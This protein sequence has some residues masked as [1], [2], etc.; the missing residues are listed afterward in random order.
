LIRLLKKPAPPN[1]I[2][3][4]I[5]AILIVFPILQ[6]GAFLVRPGSSA[7]QG[8]TVAAEG[9][10]VQ[11]GQA[12]PDVYYIILDEYGREDVLKEV[13]N[14]DNSEF[15]RYLKNKGFY[16]ADQGATN[17]GITL[18]SISSSLNSTYLDGYVSPKPGDEK[19][20]TQQII[21]MVNRSKARSAFEQ[22]GYRFVSF[23]TGYLFTEIRDADLYYQPDNYIN[24]FEMEYINTTVLSLG[25][26][27]IYGPRTRG[28]TLNTIH[29]LAE[30]P[31]IAPDRPKFVFAHILAAHVPFVF[32]PNGEAVEPWTF[33]MAASSP[34]RTYK[35]AYK[36]QVT[37]INKL[38]EAT[39]D[40]I[41]AKS[42][43]KPVIILQGDHGPETLLDW[44]SIDNTCLKERMTILNAYYLPGIDPQK[45]YPTI[46]PV[47]TFR[48]VEDH[49]LGMHE[50]LLEDHSY[51]STWDK[52]YQY[53]DVT[54]RLNSC[55][56]K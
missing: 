33:S 14:Y 38:M 10:S 2:L 18:M 52:S 5:S 50:G 28:L 40:E 56:L 27:A 19:I 45:L 47:N 17:Y 30:L 16:V 37:Y 26:G 4:I 46:T 7:Q 12:L 55:K 32:G 21:H 3:N 6:I 8:K 41:L 49:Y 31:T 29:R 9:V 44:Y 39:I 24:D 36:D 51:F 15:I 22:A 11:A 54:G 1:E 34:D 20:N 25:S 35:T 43:V 13:M 42:K 53:I 48:L 23:A